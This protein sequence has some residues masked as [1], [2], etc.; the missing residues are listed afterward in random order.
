MNMEHEFKKGDIPKGKSFVYYTQPGVEGEIYGMKLIYKS[1][2]SGKI[3]VFIT[4]SASP[5]AVMNQ[6]KDMGCDIEQFKNRLFFVDA[7]N[8]LISFPSKEK[9]VVSD[10]DNIQDFNKTVINVMKELPPSTVV[11]GSLSTIMDL[12][13]EEETIEAVRTWNKIAMLYDHVIVY[14]FT[15]WQYSRKTLNSMRKDLFN[16]VISV[17][18]N[19]KC[20]T[21]GR[22]F[23][24]DK[25]RTSC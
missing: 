19:A 12:C 5:T 25:R 13:G 16:A 15:A 22:C 10:P 11:F 7:F 6:F 24:D 18:G 21:F 8:P 9:Y 20:V 23:E 2:R 4:S 17:G 14:N 1:L 3:C